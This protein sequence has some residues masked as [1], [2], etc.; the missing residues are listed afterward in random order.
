MRKY[1]CTLHDDFLVEEKMDGERIQVHYMNYGE[2]I[3]FFSR[4]GIDYTYLYGASLSSGT[5]SQHLR[6]TDSV[7][8]CVL[9]GEMV[10]FDAKRRV[11][12]PFGLVKGSAKEALSFN[13]IN[14][15]DFHPLYMVFDLLYLNGTSFAHHY[16]FIKGSNI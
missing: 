12:L 14:N 3:K 11:I 13:S 6:F 10:T 16:P 1:A 4:R 5:I 9:D 8:E 15:V 2:S 7:K